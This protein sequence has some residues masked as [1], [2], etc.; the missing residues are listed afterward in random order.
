MKYITRFLP[1]FITMAFITGCQTMSV[2]VH[3]QPTLERAKGIM[4]P[5]VDFRSAN[6]YDAVDFFR[7]ASKEFANNKQG[8]NVIFISNDKKTAG[9]EPRLFSLS[10][11]NVSLYDAVR[12]IAEVMRLKL[13]V[14]KNTIVLR[15]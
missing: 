6:I 1:V 12:Y 13:E 14:D 9:P 15:D 3:D 8:V 4:I 5:E 7:S 10:L 2:V 11:Q